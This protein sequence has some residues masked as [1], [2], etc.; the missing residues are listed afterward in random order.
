MKN[1]HLVTTTGVPQVPILPRA[2]VKGGS[3]LNHLFDTIN[4][5]VHEGLEHAGIIERVC[6]AYTHEQ[7]VSWQPGNHVHHHTTGLQVCSTDS[8]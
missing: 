6:V 3:Y 2:N 5:A 8:R 7:D 4:G 1:G